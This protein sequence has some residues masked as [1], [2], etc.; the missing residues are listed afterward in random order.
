MVAG[1]IIELANRA[2]VLAW[3]SPLGR[4]VRLLAV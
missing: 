4:D 2:A 3:R 1:D